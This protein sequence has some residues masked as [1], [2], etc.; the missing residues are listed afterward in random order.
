MVKN[1]SSWYRAPVGA[2]CLLGRMDDPSAL[3]AVISV[4]IHALWCIPQVPG[5]SGL[6]VRL[7]GDPAKVPKG[8]REQY[9][10][11]LLSVGHLMAAEASSEELQ[12]AATVVWDALQQLPAAVE[13]ARGREASRRLKQAK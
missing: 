2:V 10:G 3:T 9:Q 11:F 6:A 4:Q 5:H 8:A 1:S 13:P 7:L 12:S